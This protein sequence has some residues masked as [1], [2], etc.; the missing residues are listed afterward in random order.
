MKAQ[1]KKLLYLR[2]LHSEAGRGSG[3]RGP[4]REPGEGLD[5]KMVTGRSRQHGKVTGEKRDYSKMLGNGGEKSVQKH[6]GK[7]NRT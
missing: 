6:G 7:H 5:W 4:G 1:T 3:K 2:D